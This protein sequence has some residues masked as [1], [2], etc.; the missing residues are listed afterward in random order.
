M[1]EPLNNI[2]DN[3]HIKLCNTTTAQHVQYVQ[4]GDHSQPVLLK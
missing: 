2:F 3:K 1:L 4:V